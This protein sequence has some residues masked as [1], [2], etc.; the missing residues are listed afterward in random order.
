ISE[1]PSGVGWVERNAT[2]GIRFR[3]QAVEQL[4]QLFS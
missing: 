4:S 3:K 1:A 2:F